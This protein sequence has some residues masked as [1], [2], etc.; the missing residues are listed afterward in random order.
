[1]LQKYMIVS[2][3]SQSGDIIFNASSV[4]SCWEEKRKTDFFPIKVHQ[5]GD[6]KKG[7]VKVVDIAEFEKYA[8]EDRPKVLRINVFKF[9]ICLVVAFLN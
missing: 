9:F 1:M 7:T 6:Q 8:S 4:Y 3:E 5:I 2:D